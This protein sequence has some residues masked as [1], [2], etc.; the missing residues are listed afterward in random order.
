MFALI[1]IDDRATVNIIGGSY[2]TGGS[3][4]NLDGLF[5]RYTQTYEL[6]DGIINR[7]RVCSSS[8]RRNAR[9]AAKK[10]RKGTQGARKREKSA[11][12][13]QKEI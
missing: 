5:S 13:V 6:E 10:R 12:Y 4:S 3:N 11:I 8:D 1:S 7:R 2:T 9:T